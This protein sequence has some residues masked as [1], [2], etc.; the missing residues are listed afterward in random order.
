MWQELVQRGIQK[1]DRRRM[2]LQFLEH[3]YEI[4]LLVGQDFGQ[5]LSPVFLG[6]SQN[7]FAHGVNAI[8]FKEHVLAAAQANANSTERDAVGRLF[9]RV[10]VGPDPQPRAALPAQTPGWGL[11][12]YQ[13]HFLP[14]SRGGRRPIRVQIYFSSGGSGP[15]R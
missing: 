5:R 14:P 11:M 7:H 3:S 15:R 1:P 8:A 4:L 13:K 12:P 6:V 10:G 9:R 2:S